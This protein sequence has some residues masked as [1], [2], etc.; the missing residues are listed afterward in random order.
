MAG[1]VAPLCPLY[2]LVTA[3]LAF[4]AILPLQLQV[5][6]MCSLTVKCEFVHYYLKKKKKKCLIQNL[7]F[8]GIWVFHSDHIT[9]IKDVAATQPPQHLCHLLRMLK[10]KGGSFFVPC[11]FFPLVP[12]Y[13]RTW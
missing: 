2:F 1:H 6:T 5:C 8:V 7:I 4:A 3:G 9:F 13:F 11:F 10:T 12:R